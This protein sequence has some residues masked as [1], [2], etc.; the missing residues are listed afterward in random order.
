MESI[1]SHSKFIIPCI[2]SDLIEVAKFLLTKR[3]NIVHIDLDI[4]CLFCHTVPVWN[5]IFHRV[6]ITIRLRIWSWSLKKEKKWN[7]K[8]YCV[9]LNTFIYWEAKLITVLRMYVK[10]PET[11]LEVLS[12]LPRPNNQLFICKAEQWYRIIS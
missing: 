11:Y 12:L 1:F 7:D 2:L 4:I 6:W 8:F 3:G 5:D 10:K 9:L